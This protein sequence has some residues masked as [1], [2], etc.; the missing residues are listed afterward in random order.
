VSTSSAPPRC[1]PTTR[2]CARLL[3]LG[4]WRTLAAETAGGHLVVVP[5]APDAVLL[6]A[7]DRS[8]PLGRLAVVAGRTAAAARRW[9]EALA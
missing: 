7:R 1:C 9:L 3:G 6:V 8:V 5:A 2:G 4:A